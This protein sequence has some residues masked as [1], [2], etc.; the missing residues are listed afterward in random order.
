MADGDCTIDANDLPGMLDRRSFGKF[1]AALAVMA[2]TAHS[3]SGASADESLEITEA[4]V[5]EAERIAG[6]SFTPEERKTLVGQLKSRIKNFEE[7]RALNIPNSIPPALHFNPAP[8]GFVGAPALD[9][10]KGHS[11]AV[12]PAVWNGSRPSDPADLA[13]LSA[14]QLASLIR[15]GKLSPVELTE[16]YIHRLK[17]IGAKLNCIVTM[18]EES[19]L[20]EAASA[21]SEI[22]AGRIR[23]PLHGI[24]WGAKDLFATRGVRTTW[25]AKPFENQIIDEDAAV[26]T[27]LREA[28]AILVAKLSLGELAQGDVWMNGKTR[29]PWNLERGSS[30]SSA[31]PAA[32]T[33]AGLVGFAIGTETL[34]SIVSPSSV[35]G[36]SGLRPTFGRVSRHGAMALAWSMDKIG[37]MGRCVEDC[38]L[39]FAAIHGAD[40]RDP[41]AVTASFHWPVAVDLSSLRVGYEKQ[42]FDA[43]GNDDDK[44][45]DE[46]ALD[47][48]KSLG[49]KL[50]PIQLP[51]YPL[52]AIRTVLTVEAAAAFDEL[53]RSNQDD[54]LALQGNAGWPSIFRSNRFVPAVEYVQAQRARTM[55]MR[56]M[57]KVMENFDVFVAPARLSRSLTLTNLTGHPTVVVPH[58]FVGGMPRAICF[59][60]HLYDDARLLAIARAYQESTNWHLKH[61]VIG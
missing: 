53:T 32:A 19:A 35:C 48:L 29:N 57:A 23:G 31:G 54:L 33:A 39:A 40:G 1:A 41:A 15:S 59:V 27:R 34:G 50:A 20:Q 24:T 16:I 56:D 43:A 37:P 60:G 21:E 6:L 7:I 44:R 12:E 42:A 58:G 5:A 4:A 46:A 38:A 18:L 61:P 8:A 28:G 36:V 10:Q 30:G 13:F 47:A 2:S 17:T 25:G 3:P 11:N 49:A 9:G 55:L 26:V 45:A 52:G 22:K 14:Y 51:D